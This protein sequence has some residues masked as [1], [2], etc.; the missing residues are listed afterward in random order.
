MRP[1]AAP[2]PGALTRASFPTLPPLAGGAPRVLLIDDDPS[3]CEL[4][5]KHLEVAGYQVMEARSGDEG[6]HLARTERPDA[7]TLDVVMPNVDGFGVLS[8]L[9]RDPATASIPVI[10]LSIVE[11]KLTG[12]SLGA[13]EYLVKPV[14]RDELERVLARHCPQGVGAPRRVMVVE[15]DAMAREVVENMLRRAGYTAVCAG[16]GRLALERL[17]AEEAPSA[18]LVDLMMPEMDGFELVERLRADARWRDVPVIVLT[19]KVITGEERERLRRGV[20][21]IFEKGN[22]RSGDLLDELRRRIDA[23]VRRRRISAPPAASR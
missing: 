1:Q 7:I 23:A 14:R 11:D 15:D 2:N 5:R 20:Q 4:M 6:L 3:V 10:V 16:N 21:R 22:Y 9:K 17:E 19:A 13:A 12:F 18:I 8:A